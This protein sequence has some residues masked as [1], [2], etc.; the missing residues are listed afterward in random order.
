MSDLSIVVLAFNGCCDVLKRTLPSSKN[1]MPN[2]KFFVATSTDQ[3]EVL[4]LCSSMGIASIQFTND[5]I[6]KN[7]A[8]FNYAGIAR[9]CMTFARNE[10]KKEHWVLITR[11]QVN[12]DSR[13]GDLDL[14]TLAKDSLY[15]CGM[16]ELITKTD[17]EKYKP[18]VPNAQE[19]RELIPTSSFLL[20]FSAPPQ[21]DAW[22]TDTHS[23]VQRFSACF[24]A[25]YMIH[26]KLAYLGVLKEDDDAKVSEGPWGFKKSEILRIE[27]VHAYAAKQEEEAV[28]KAEKAEK[29][30][31][32]KA[33]KEAA[34]KEAAEKAAE[35]AK[36]EV[37]VPP[38]EERVPEKVEEPEAPKSIKS[39]LFSLLSSDDAEEYRSRVRTEF[40]A[41]QNVA[42]H[43]RNKEYASSA[44]KSIKNSI[45]SAKLLD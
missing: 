10:M 41:Q 42:S 21:F 1:A 40:D 23:A 2:A 4:A 14:S 17:L 13:I 26:L 7:G 34:E 12:L 24:I 8:T 32:E 19:V 3:T 44:P 9:A 16:M 5:T 18:T 33:E 6:K 22:S 37:V 45:W 27:P 43:E 31:A 35:K 25:K 38:A 28:E 11:A 30:A 15:G 39:K 20:S 36:E 29:E